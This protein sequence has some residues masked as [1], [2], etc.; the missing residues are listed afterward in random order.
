MSQTTVEIRL[1]KAN[2]PLWKRHSKSSFGPGALAALKG[3][4]RLPF[5]LLKYI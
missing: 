4:Y 3:R 5:L 2:W 1:D